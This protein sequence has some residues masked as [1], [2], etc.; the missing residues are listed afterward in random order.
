VS[1]PPSH[2]RE[3]RKLVGR[4]DA[5]GR[6]YDDLLG[7]WYRAF[8]EAMLAL[9]PVHVL[10]VSYPTYSPARYTAAIVAYTTLVVAVGLLAGGWVDPGR[11]LD[12]RWPGYAPSSVVARVVAYNG[13]VRAALAGGVALAG[14]PALVAGWAVATTVVG[15]LAV[16]PLTR[17]A[18]AV[19][20][21]ARR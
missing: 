14:R 4:A 10:F 9:G 15:A 3:E 17:A 16:P 5:D 2:E 18:R 12:W 21:T 1:G 20:T 8:W 13:S 11:R 19:L 6:S 7:D